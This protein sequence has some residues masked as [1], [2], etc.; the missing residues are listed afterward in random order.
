M[1]Q[2][3]RATM[4]RT[5]HPPVRRSADA[6][7]TGPAPLPRLPGNQAQLRR[8]AVARQCAAGAGAET[9]KPAV[10]RAPAQPVLATG[11]PAPPAVATALAGSG[12]E[13]P[14]AAR[15]FFEP[16]FGVDFAPVRLHTGPAAAAA[17]QAIGARAFTLGTDIG[18]AAGACAPAT[19]AGARLLAH[20]LAHVV[21]QVGGAPAV[22]RAPPE[23]QPE[24]A[25]APAALKEKALRQSLL[26]EEIHPLSTAALKD[27]AA[28]I[29]TA[30]APPR[31]QDAQGNLD[32]VTAE[33]KTRGPQTCPP[34]KEP[35]CQPAHVSPAL[36]GALMGALPKD[37]GEGCVETPYPA[38]NGETVCT[39]GYGHQLP[40]CPALNGA[41]GKPATQAEIDEANTVKPRG[42]PPKTRSLRPGE[43][44]TCACAGTQPRYDCKGNT[45]R[46]QLE[47][48]IRVK[49]NHVHDVVPV[50]LTQA[51]FDA[52]VDIALHVGSV[53]ASL[54]A[55]VARQ[56][57]TAKGRNAVRE[58]YMRTALTAQ[59]GKTVMKGFVERRRNRV[60][61]AEAEAGAAAPPGQS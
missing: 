51:Q 4:I 23:P 28:H 55:E 50:P 56:W 32:R 9:P 2:S 27:L 33:L 61:P 22:Q 37:P 60:W 58:L 29:E 26:P 13:L 35:C 42:E 10:Q 18:F 6:A 30:L 43:W 12:R 36:K 53:P 11:G 48:D 16:R 5:P 39:I 49:E 59:G 7:L 57:C 15:A 45:P 1:Q 41:T 46:A 31:A 20:E 3:L 21:Q 52:F 40:D 14:P 19:P 34:P 17:A 54:L 44:L 25:Q 24:Q 47:Q 38:G 8:L